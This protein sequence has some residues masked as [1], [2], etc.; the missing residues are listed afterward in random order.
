MKGD[1]IALVAQYQPWWTTTYE[2][3][4]RTVDLASM[5]MTSAQGYPL[6]D[7]AE[8]EEIV[9]LPDY[10]TLVLLQR[11]QFLSTA[12]HYAYV[13]WKPYKIPPYYADL[14]YESGDNPFHSIDRLT[15]KHIVATGGD[16]WMEKDVLTNNPS[17]SC[18]TIDM[19]K[20]SPLS[21][22]S[23]VGGV[24]P[25]HSLAPSFSPPFPIC[26]PNR[27]S[28]PIFCIGF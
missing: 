8:P 25:Y 17:A 18:Y 13:Y 28:I 26:F 12:Y 23:P 19:Q 20:I 22:A 10:A 27:Y 6:L 21:S 11:Q 14:I 3:H 15:H 4:M 1:T 5:T 9:Y 16:Y 24:Y 2:T 7:K